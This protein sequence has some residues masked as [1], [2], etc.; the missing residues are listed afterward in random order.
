MATQKKSLKK[1]GT[2]KPLLNKIAGKAAFIA[3]EVVGT[4][5][6]I[7]E[8]ATDK[9]DAVKA[10]IHNITAKK[11]PAS[12]KQVKAAVKKVVKKA[13][14]AKKA[15]KKVVKKAA[16]AKKAIKKAVKKVARKK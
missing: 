8:M 14:P 4:K 9:I 3:G 16:P 6:A 7:V 1:A 5:N 11:K 13:A 10:T 15:I 2:Q 12:K